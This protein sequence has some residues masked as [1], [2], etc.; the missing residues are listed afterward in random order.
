MKER[1][2]SAKEALKEHYGKRN[3]KLVEFGVEPLRTPTEK[4]RRQRSKQIETPTEPPA[5]TPD[6]VK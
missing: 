1:A 4:R 5:P 6:S 2:R 3:E